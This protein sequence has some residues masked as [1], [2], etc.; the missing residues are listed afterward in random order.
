MFSLSAP[1]LPVA[2]KNVCSLVFIETELYN[3]GYKYI[4]ILEPVGEF[5]LSEVGGMAHRK[6]ENAARRFRRIAAVVLLAA[7]LAFCVIFVKALRLPVLILAALAGAA[8]GYMKAISH[9][10]NDGT[11]D[12]PVF[13]L[14]TLLIRLWQAGKPRPV[15]YEEKLTEAEAP[16]VL[17][18]NHESFFDFFY[19]LQLSHPK[20]PCFLISEYYYTRPILR[21]FARHMGMLPKKIFSPE[22]AV[23]LRI[24]R[25]LK[26]GYPVIIFPEGRLSP[27]G[28][29]NPIVEE[30]AAFYKRLNADLV[31]V[32][33][34]G[35]YFACPKWRGKRYRSPVTVTVEEVI[36]KDALRTMSDED[37]NRKIADTLYGDASK[38][39]LCDYPQRDKARNLGNLLYRCADCGALYTMVG[40][41][42]DLLCTA[43][44][45]RHTLNNQ[46]QFTDAPYSIPGWY[47]RMRDMERAEL[48]SLTLETPVRT[49]I[50]GRDGGKNRRETGV[51]TLTPEALSY[52]SEQIAF[53]IPTEQIPGLAFSCGTEFE[54][55]YEGEL[56]FFYP[57][58]H[59]QQTA[60]WALLVDLLAEQR[61]DFIRPT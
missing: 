46:Y 23:S 2:G 13:G 60:R 47:G 3:Y 12:S 6:E 43:C 50:H 37:L 39:L 54:L 7:V 57:L 4:F 34:R 31:L 61:R 49:L 27:D 21:T 25:M 17:L 30:G 59:P 38:E 8:Y 32:K 53:S 40:R 15:L 5:D 33:L 10:Q 16:Y 51:C 28:R 24:M 44:G 45:R 52:R 1:N 14:V 26:K 29:S 56:Y 9:D 11:P 36:K 42:N 22:L 18:S 48:E 20:H 55:Y 58:E 41:G 19:M 35:A